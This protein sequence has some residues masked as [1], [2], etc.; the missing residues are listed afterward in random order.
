MSQSAKKSATDTINRGIFG[1][2]VILFHMI[3]AVQF[4]YSVYYDY[5]FVHIPEGLRRESRG[6]N[7][8]Y[9]GKLKYLTFIDAVSVRPLLR[10]NFRVHFI[11]ICSYH[12]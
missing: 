6:M 1:S 4:W 2:L 5:N 7:D 12:R 8:N 3:G 11:I 10:N 9:G